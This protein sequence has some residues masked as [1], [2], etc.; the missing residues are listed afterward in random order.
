M[1]SSQLAKSIEQQYQKKTPIEHVLERPDTY[2]GSTERMK[3]KLFCLDSVNNIKL[4]EVDFIPAL[5]RIID[6]IL[7]NAVDNHHRKGTHTNELRVT[8]DEAKNW[9]HIRN[10]G[11]SVPVEMHKIEKI[12]VPE[13][14]FGNLLTGSNFDDNEVKFT[15]GRN[16]YGAKLANI[17]STDFTIEIMDHKGTH[18]IQNW[19]KNMSQIST[20]TI[21]ENKQKTEPYI[22]V[23]FHP[24]FKKF[25]STGLNKELNMIDLL[26]RRIYDLSACNPKLNVYLNDKKV[27]VDNFK[28]Y[29]KLFYQNNSSGEHPEKM[30]VHK[31]ICDG[32]EIAI[33][34]S[35]GEEFNQISF[36]NS[37]ATVQGGS[38][39]NFVLNQLSTKISEYIAKTYTDLQL[40]ISPYMV[41]NHITLFINSLIENPTF[42]S[43][44]KETLTTKSI[45]FAQKVV[46]SNDLINSIANHTPI[47]DNIIAF[48]NYKQSSASSK[49]FKKR[50]SKLLI[51]KLD[52]ANLAG[53]NRSMECVLILTEGDSAK[54]LA[55]SGLS[56]V[57][58]DRFGVFPLKGKLLNVREAS[59][60]QIR[61]NQEI[62]NLKKILGLD[63]VSKT[64]SFE[65]LTKRL[66][67]GK[68]MLMCDQDHDGS[69]IKGLLLNMIHFFYPELLRNN[70]VDEFITPIIKVSKGSDVKSFFS[71][72]E[73][74]NWWTKVPENEKNRWNQK[75]YKGL[76]T[77]SSKEAKDYFSNL[78]RHVIALQYDD[79]SEPNI[80]LAF[81]K[82]LANAR[83]SWVA[84][85][86]DG[87]FLDTTNGKVT[88]TDFINNELIL[89]SNQ[90]NIRSIPS[91]VDGLK[92]SQR[93][94]LF[95]CLKRDLKDEIKVAQ[96]AGYVSEHSAYHHGEQSLY[97][98]IT[99]MAQDFV[100]AN[101][102]PL[103]YPSG[104]FGTRL[105]GG[106]DAASA[107][108]IYTRLN[109]LTRLIFLKEDDQILDY[110]EE[111]GMI[112]EP[113]FYLPIIPMLL[114]NG[115]EGMGT[116]WSTSIPSFNPIDLIDS[117]NILLDSNAENIGNV[118]LPSL[119]MW[120]RGFKGKIEMNDSG[121]FISKGIFKM[122]SRGDS[123]EFDISELPIG[124]WTENYKSHLQSLVKKGLIK[125]KITERN[126]EN[127]VGFTIAINDPDEF[128]ESQLKK[129]KLEKSFSLSNM[130]VFSEN[131]DI[132][133]FS[134]VNDIIK[135][136]YLVR[137]SYYHQR[138]SHLM[139]QLE[140]QIRILSNKVKFLNFI[141]SNESNLNTFIKTKKENIP[142]FLTNVV[143]IVVDP[144]T[145]EQSFNY[146]TDMNILSLTHEH[147]DRINKQL[148]SAQQ[149]LQQVS[150]DDP[151]LMW[152]RDLKRLRDEL[153]KSENWVV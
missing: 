94:I 112:I 89:F 68:V 126:T 66:R 70:F 20:P 98:T 48:A 153:T 53:T 91:I 101:N 18:Y 72:P 14:V 109:K 138:K 34:A 85:L 29:V 82:D 56:V 88:I 52:D 119:D 149:E 61:D 113:K 67:Y 140:K 31:H 145:I 151:K 84:S 60:D 148:E 9:I 123:I 137:L 104:Q 78:K 125:S 127:S 76:G 59:A 55:I 77:N 51:P 35:V 133:Q 103:L 90:N 27:E 81:S 116:G 62:Q 49:K 50:E 24:D 12:Y 3:K 33:G 117:L 43:Q 118:K 83:K 114:V 106:D 141:T 150:S 73:F 120:A 19:K 65:E 69:H 32:W 146:L 46:I 41:R 152:K 136:F 26:K 22:Q 23:S 75:Y 102:I 8:I 96:L 7:V 45:S 47:I 42:D 38:H 97:G 25:Q 71:I 4:K 99:S 134:N 28:E 36:V 44:T 6:E 135:Q 122:K 107:R 80:E 15:G 10:N 37:I 92:P 95:A 124:E 58:R 87:T 111:D 2:V 5:Y 40:T 16:G 1:L 139:K 121:K 64:D 30:F 79:D 129:L 86:K 57:G 128:S 115:A 39:V 143:G 130:T 105:Q 132:I 11:K 13:L 144:T 147:K 108:Y 131:F 100:G 142:S 21:V 63:D 74:Q 110:Q 93:K 17:F 54:A